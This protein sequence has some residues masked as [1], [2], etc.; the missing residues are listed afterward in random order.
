MR[1]EKLEQDKYT[2]VDCSIS[3]KKINLYS[4]LIILPIYVLYTVIYLLRWDYANIFA[5]IF[6]VTF[7]LELFILAIAIIIVQLVSLVIKGALLSALSEGKWDFVKF[8]FLAENQKPYVTINEPLT[9]SQY[10]FCQA[11]YIICFALLPFAISMM[12]GDFMFVLASFICV[13]IAGSDILF[14]FNL[15]KHNGNSYMIDYNG[16]F[17]YKIYNSKK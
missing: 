5:T 7:L 17:L 4:G 13:L 16:I 14:F 15:L 2:S 12:I 1:I 9:V 10:R 11:V 6:K 3:P 8:K